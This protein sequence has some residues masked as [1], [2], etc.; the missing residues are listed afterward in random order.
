MITFIRSFLLNLGIV[1]FFVFP[2]FVFALI[3]YAAIAYPDYFSV[4]AA[5][6]AVFILGHFSFTKLYR[7]Y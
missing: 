7:R 1:V 5:F 6:V 4:I 3:V 2:F